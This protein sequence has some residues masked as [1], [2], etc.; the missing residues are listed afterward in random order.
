M[1][2]HLEPKLPTLAASM[3]DLIS[4][5]DR[6][7]IDQLPSN[8]MRTCRKKGFDFN[9]LIAGNYQL[10]QKEL[11]ESLFGVTLDSSELEMQS[12]C[13]MAEGK[14]YVK[15]DNVELK[16]GNVKLRVKIL[17]TPNFGMRI[18]E[19]NS[20]RPIVKNVKERLSQH[21]SQ[22]ELLYR[23]K[24]MP[25]C[26]IHLCLYLLSPAGLPIHPVDLELMKRL[27]HVCNVVPV[28]ARSDYM[29]ETERKLRK[30]AITDAIIQHKLKIF[31]LPQGD[32][33][34]DENQWCEHLNQ[35]ASRQPFACMCDTPGY[36][37]TFYPH[38]FDAMNARMSDTVVLRS[39]IIAHMNE[40]VDVTHYEHYEEFRAEVKKRDMSDSL[41]MRQKVDAVELVDF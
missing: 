23:K 16:D 26:R 22:E 25:D 11:V 14:S 7:E 28:I 15:E 19:T 17:T 41:V 37:D 5:R 29:T 21:L 18:D 36:F 9:I 35:I 40:L 34:E 3:N 27:C 24:D 6:I 2:D 1:T 31:Q 38:E 30:E 39:A 12:A 13:Q 32:P 4:G 8:L 33:E 10:G 20:Y